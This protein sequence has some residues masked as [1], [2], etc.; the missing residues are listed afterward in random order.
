MTEGLWKISSL[1]EI[2]CVNPVDRLLGYLY[3]TVK[4]LGI[5]ATLSSKCLQKYFH[6]P[7]SPTQ[8]HP[9]IST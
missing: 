6:F 8:S 1:S 2:N 7:T 9:Q 3:N 4:L 5:N